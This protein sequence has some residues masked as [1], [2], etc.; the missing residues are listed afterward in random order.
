MT[1][2]EPDWV[3][4][5]SKTI[6]TAILICCFVVSVLVGSL[7]GYAID[8]YLVDR[9][10]MGYALGGTFSYLVLYAFYRTLKHFSKK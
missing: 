8:L 5:L 2:P 10:P 9:Q 1:E 4:A 6:G 3:D 7:F